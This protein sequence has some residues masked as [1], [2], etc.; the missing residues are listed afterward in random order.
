M[1]SL[2]LRWAR[3]SRQV[4]L[5]EINVRYRVELD[6]GGAEFGQDFIPFLNSRRMPKQHRIFEWCA[7]PGFIGF[8]LL[9]SGLSETLCLA[10]INPAAVSCCRQTVISNNLSDRVA[11]YRSNNLRD[12]PVSEKWDLIVSNPPHFIDQY[13]GDIRAHDPGWRIHQEFFAT[14]QPHLSEQGIIV[15]QE[16]NRGST[17]DTFRQMIDENGLEILFVH[18]DQ[19]ILTKKSSVYFIGIGPKLRTHP[20]WVR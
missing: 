13:V 7:G 3:P 4:K 16:N 6:G 12:I 20:T 10:D 14:V 17:V 18:G 19:P 8:S 5:A 9:G 11:V 15:L 2:D 1:S